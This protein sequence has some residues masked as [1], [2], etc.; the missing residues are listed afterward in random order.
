MK[1]TRLLV[2]ALTL[3]L[4]FNGASANVLAQ[5]SDEKATVQT[6]RPLAFEEE[7]NNS[8]SEAAD[9]FGV[10]DAEPA[11]FIFESEIFETPTILMHNDEPL[12]GK[13]MYPSP[14]LF[15]VDNDGQDELVVGSIFGGIVS[16]ENGTEGEGEP[17][18]EN[19]KPVESVDGKP[20]NLNN[21]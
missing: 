10:N 17:T 13:I 15:D 4:A 14:A 6:K 11:E 2:G 21:W 7:D 1:F 20:L 5:E 3:T 19:Q 16:F 9:M 12:A 8:D 18:W